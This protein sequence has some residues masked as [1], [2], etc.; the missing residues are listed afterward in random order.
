MK[1][2]YP[3]QSF[4][5][6]FKYRINVIKDKG[7]SPLCCCDGKEPPTKLVAR[8][9]RNKEVGTAAEKLD[10]LFQKG[11]VGESH[12]QAEIFKVKTHVKQIMNP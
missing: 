1:P 12:S 10:A 7:I 11:R 9:K 4:R 6:A 2:F 3:P 8:A 5:D